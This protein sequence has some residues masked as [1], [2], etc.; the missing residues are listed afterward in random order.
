MVGHPALQGTAELKEAVPEAGWEAG[1]NPHDKL[2]ALSYPQFPQ[3]NATEHPT[4]PVATRTFT[5]T[6]LVP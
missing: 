5:G 4:L 1:T 3:Q 6:L 2:P